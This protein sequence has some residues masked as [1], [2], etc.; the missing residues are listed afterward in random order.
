MPCVDW[1][2]RLMLKRWLDEKFDSESLADASPGL[3]DLVL[4]QN[5]M[6]IIR[7]IR[8]R[9]ACKNCLACLS[10]PKC[11]EPWNRRLQ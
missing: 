7:V 9:S 3:S 8:Q 5:F 1:Q 4:P 2:K 10:T 6:G 11:R